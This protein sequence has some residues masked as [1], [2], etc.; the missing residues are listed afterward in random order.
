MTEYEIG[1]IYNICIK[2]HG[3][4]FEGKTKYKNDV[5]GTGL[6]LAVKP[7]NSKTLWCKANRGNYKS[8]DFDLTMITHNGIKTFSTLIYKFNKLS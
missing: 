7:T 8:T 2:I 5:I 4:L 3:I 6:L 1:E